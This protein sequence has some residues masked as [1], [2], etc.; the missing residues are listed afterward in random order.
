MTHDEVRM[1][2]LDHLEELRQRIIKAVIGIVIA[3]AVCYFFSDQLIGLFRAPA[4]DMIPSGFFVQGLLDA[5]FIRIKVAAYGGI[6]IS[7][8]VWAWQFIQFIMPGLTD[9]EKKFLYPALFGMVGLFLFGTLI[10]YLTLP[11]TIR[12]LLIALG[13]QFQYLPIASNYI[14]TV[15]YYLLAFGLA[16]ETP[17]VILA[18]VYVGILTPQQLRK[19]RRIAY[20]VMYAFGVIVIPTNDPFFTPMMIMLPMIVLYEASIRLAD[21]IVARR[22]ETAL[23]PTGR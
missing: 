4:G 21:R 9:D 12:F 20:F 13:D 17:V 5:F 8:P 23:T 1:S 3:T 11:T 16:F 6:I 22:D 18:L 10:G 7:S 2:I 15:V 19:Q 14:S